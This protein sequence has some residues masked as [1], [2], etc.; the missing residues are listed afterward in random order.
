MDFMTSIQTVLGKYAD[1]DGRARRS[2]FWWWFL[3]VVVVD[4]VLNVLRIP[5]LGILFGL[6][7]IVPNLAVGCRRLHDTGK[8]GWL[9]LVGLIPIVGWILLIVWFAAEGT[10]GPNQYGPNPKEGE[11]GA[12]PMGYGAPPPPPGA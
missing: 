8:S 3:A 11:M 5:V 9:Q 1:F 4:V 10:P 6:A 2:E 12:P 7:I